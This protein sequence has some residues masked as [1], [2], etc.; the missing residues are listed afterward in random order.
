M[1]AQSAD[2]YEIHHSNLVR[3]IGAC[4]HVHG[5]AIIVR[6]VALFLGTKNVHKT[7]NK[8]SDVSQNKQSSKTLKD[9]NIH[10]YFRVV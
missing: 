2:S 9:P 6:H 1:V 4:M 3:D 7:Q 10:K 8:N 5:N